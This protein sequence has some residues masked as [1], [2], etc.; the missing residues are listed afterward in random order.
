MEQIVE[1]SDDRVELVEDQPVVA[2]P[3]DAM[4]MLRGG[5]VA[6]LYF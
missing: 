1:I 3:V 6:G 5:C 4:E 2:L